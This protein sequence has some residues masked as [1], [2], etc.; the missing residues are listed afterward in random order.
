V[1]IYKNDC[2]TYIVITK[3]YF[4]AKIPLAK[5]SRYDLYNEYN[6]EVNLKVLNP[7]FL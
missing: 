3:T 4:V 1:L 7:V 5:I 6:E 2:F